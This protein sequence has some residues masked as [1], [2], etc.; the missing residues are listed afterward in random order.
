MLPACTCQLHPRQP[1]NLPQALFWHTL[2]ACVQSFVVAY[3]QLRAS[4]FESSAGG[5][6]PLQRLRFESRPR[7]VLL[8]SGRREPGG[9]GLLLFLLDM[10]RINQIA[11]VQA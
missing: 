1:F 11:P 2:A 3:S 7:F 6:G 10:Q 9:S 5:N 8:G 4:M